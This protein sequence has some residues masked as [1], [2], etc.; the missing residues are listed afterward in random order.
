ML[1]QNSLPLLDSRVQSTDTQVVVQTMV[2]VVRQLGNTKRVSGP[3]LKRAKETIEKRFNTFMAVEAARPGDPGNV[4]HVFE[5]GGRGP[6]WKLVMVGSGNTRIIT[7]EF[8]PSIVDVPIRPE[9]QGFNFKRYKFKD[10][11]TIFENDTPVTINPKDKYLVYIEDNKVTSGFKSGQGGGFVDH[12][13]TT[14]STASSEIVNP[15]GG[16]YK[17]S[18]Q[19]HFLE[20]WSSSAGAT[21]EYD[22]LAYVLTHSTTFRAEAELRSIK[23]QSFSKVLTPQYEI[24]RR[25]AEHANQIITAIAA[26]IS[27]GII[28]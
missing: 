11:A 20:F 5:W 6:L 17:D 18:F 22:E 13:G 23:L 16:R 2:E 25:A 8:L 14:F 7:Y 12:L 15:G 9:F 21:A 28:N 24:N 1:T 19:K 27:G 26:D 3:L 10:K 4:L